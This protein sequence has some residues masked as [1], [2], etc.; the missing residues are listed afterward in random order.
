MN[1]EKKPKEKVPVL[2]LSFF[3][4]V[5]SNIMTKVNAT[6]YFMRRRHFMQLVC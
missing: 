6:K 3:A 2:V 5:D 4:S 1:E